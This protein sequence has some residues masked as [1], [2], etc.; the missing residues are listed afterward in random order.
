MISKATSNRQ[1]RRRKFALILAITALA[2]SYRLYRLDTLPPGD[3]YDPALYG[4]DALKIL[5]GARPVFLPTNFGREPLFSY[6]VTAS[7]LALGPTALAV[8]LTA[9]VV[10]IMTIPAVYLLGE[11]LFVQ[12]EEPLKSY[13]GLVA[14]LMMA[15]S[16]WHLNWSRY[17]VRAILVPLFAA[18]T[19]YSLC[20][21]V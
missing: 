8:H 21:L 10:G 20:G 9:A 11:E 3:G 18:L 13:G 14:A 12:E 15:L 5:Q 19:M 7:V 16:Y 4:A 6:L 2:A 17:G 1:Y